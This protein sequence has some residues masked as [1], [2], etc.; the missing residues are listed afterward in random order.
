M[1]CDFFIK[2]ASS[3]TVW[4]NSFKLGRYN[5]GNWISTGFWD[6]NRVFDVFVVMTRNRGYLSIE[7][8]R[9]KS[10]RGSGSVGYVVLGSV[11]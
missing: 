9:G 6:C 5:R 2:L 4:I 3:W 8:W 1:G 10:C 11:L 7:R